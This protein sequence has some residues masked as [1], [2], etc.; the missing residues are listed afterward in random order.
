MIHWKPIF[1]NNKEIIILNQNI[2]IAMHKIIIELKKYSINYII[3]NKNVCRKIEK[4]CFT[5]V[6]YLL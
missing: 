5:I 3:F 1:A 6:Y 4:L 2:T